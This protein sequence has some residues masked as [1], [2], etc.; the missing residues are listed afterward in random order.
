[1][2]LKKC[3]STI[4]MVSFLFSI[5]AGPMGCGKK[6]D[7]GSYVGL[8]AARIEASLDRISKVLQLNPD[9]TVSLDK[10]DPDYVSLVRGDTAFGKALLASL[11]AKVQE[12]LIRVNP[13]FSAAWLG[14]PSSCT[15]CVGGA[16]CNTNWWGESCFVSSSTTKDICVALA[17][18]GG[19]L[20]ICNAIPVVSEACDIIEVVGVIPLE[21][22]ITTCVDMGRS[23]TFHVTWIDIAWF[24]CN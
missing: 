2:R 13:D 15:Q 4:L 9:G 8:R 18:G 14:P 11:N 19:A 23:S 22:E 20:V 21:A 24:T 12:G 7:A 3:I 5:T 10:T 16:S 17:A 1:M 6:S